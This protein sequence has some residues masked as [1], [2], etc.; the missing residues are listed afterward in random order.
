[1]NKPPHEVKTRVIYTRVEPA[2][3]DR[4]SA[5]AKKMGVPVSLCVR[6]AI[7]DFLQGKKTDRQKLVSNDI[8]GVLK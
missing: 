6:I 5:A 4:L 1:M 7:Q 2:V 8:Q 3:K